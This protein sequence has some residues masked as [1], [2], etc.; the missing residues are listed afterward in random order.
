MN[1]RNEND[2]VATIRALRDAWERGDKDAVDEHIHYPLLVIS[3]DGIVSLDSYPLS[4]ELFSKTTTWTHSTTRRVSVEGI[5]GTKAHVSINGC[6]YH[7][8]GTIF[9]QYYVIYILHKYEQKWKVYA[10]S[11]IAI[12]EKG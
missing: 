11:E 7:K 2:I 5:C 10:V 12:P 3:M 4:N 8:N 6:R 9:E 1:E